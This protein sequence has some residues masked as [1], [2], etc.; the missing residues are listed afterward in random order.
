MEYRKIIYEKVEP[1]IAKIMMNCPEKRN[2]Q[3]PLMFSEMSDAFVKADFDEEV[4]VIIFG[5]VGKDFS[6]GHDLSGKGEPGIE[7]SII[8]RALSTKLTGMEMRLKRESYLYYNQAINIRNVSKPTIAMVQGHCIA[9]GWI[10]ASMCDLI[11]ASE[12][13]SF[14]DPVPRMTP[15]GVE[16]LF[17]PYDVGFR[18]AKEMLFTG[19]AITAQEAK[20]LGLVS[21]V[22]PRE[23]LEEETLVLARK[24]A[25]N[26]PIAVSLVKKSINHAWDEL[27]Q[28]NA[29]EY[30][31]LIHQLSHS[32][33]EAKRWGEER[34]KAMEKGGVSEMLK[35]R[36]GKFK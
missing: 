19:D 35:Q 1:T 28:K 6:S 8:G 14:S 4:R 5:G 23:K 9:G 31:M 17:H 11:V 33:D 2:A 3:D 12:D 36:D 24:I 10:N 29:W 15:A 30:H 18:K 16:I 34:A 32:S 21:R 20:Q 13:A 26:M 27:G 25:M 7:G 22:V